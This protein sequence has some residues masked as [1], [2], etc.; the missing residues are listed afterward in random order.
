MLAHVPNH[1]MFGGQ[2]ML[3]IY[4][5]AE[6]V[7]GYTRWPGRD[8][9]TIDPQVTNDAPGSPGARRENTADS[10]ASSDAARR[11]APP[12]A[13]VTNHGS[14]HSRCA[15]NRWQSP[16][17]QSR[18]ATYGRCVCLPLR[19][20]VGFLHMANRPPCRD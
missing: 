17:L 11:D 19:G 5:L 16:E 14:R 9:I 18:S 2:G 6:D 20:H 8:Y 3:T 4:V 13:Y 10:W 12:G 7:V 15:R 1:E